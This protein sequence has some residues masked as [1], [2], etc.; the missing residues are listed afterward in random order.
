MLIISRKI[1]KLNKAKDSINSDRLHIYQWDVSDINNMDSHFQNI[2]NELGGIDIFINNAALLDHCHTDIEHYNR[3][4]ATN[5]TS[6][7]AICKYLVDYYI[8]KNGNKG[9]KILNISSINSFQSSINPYYVSKSAVNAITR[10][11]AKEY[12]KKNIIVNAIA[13]G[14][15]A[16]SIN[17]QDVARNA[18]DD[19]SANTR[20][21][22]PEDI[23]ELAFF[24]CSDAANG[25]VGQTI[26][27][28]GGALL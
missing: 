24:L 2:E 15:C 8:K 28:D 26:V 4:I 18:Y 10:G 14:Y 13:P 23:A 19:H 3:V 6:V 20:I 9:G 1:D 16:S 11:F 5:Q 17:Y 7:Y 25:I 27:C 12:A 22:V 21:I